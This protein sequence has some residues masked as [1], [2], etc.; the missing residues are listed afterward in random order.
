M[1]DTK[2]KTPFNVRMDPD[3]L[4]QVDERAQ[5]LGVSRNEW[6]NNMTRWCL[7]NTYTIEQ[8]PLA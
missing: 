4:A 1:S 6:L 8:R 3:M 7:R 5:E 2:T